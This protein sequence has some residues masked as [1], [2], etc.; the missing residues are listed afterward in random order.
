MPVTDASAGATMSIEQEEQ[1]G[2]VE[3]V[4]GVTGDVNPEDLRD[5]AAAVI[6]TGALPVR[7]AGQVVV[8]WPGAESAGKRKDAV[9]SPRGQGDQR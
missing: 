8:S 7:A 9:G 4:I 1:E 6:A 2:G 3:L 5:R